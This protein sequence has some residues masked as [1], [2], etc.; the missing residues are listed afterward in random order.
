MKITNLIIKISTQKEWTKVAEVLNELGIKWSSGFSTTD[1]FELITQMYNE[2]THIIIEGDTI[3][4]G[5]SNSLS[6][7]PNKPIIKAKDFLAMF[8]CSLYPSLI[9]VTLNDNYMAKVSR[10]EVA[11]G[12]QQFTFEAIESLYDAIQTM[13]EEIV[14]SN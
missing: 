2:D 5:S 14:E 3:S 4:Y 1:H 7:Y 13:K 8:G 9:K 11:V 6:G 12:C 10:T